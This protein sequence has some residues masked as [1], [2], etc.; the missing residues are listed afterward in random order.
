[1]EALSAYFTKHG[2]LLSKDDAHDLMCHMFLG[3]QT[4]MIGKTEVT[5]MRTTTKPRLSVGD[6]S[7]FMSEIDAWA[8]DKGCLLP[9]PADCEY[10]RLQKRQ[11]A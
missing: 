6:F 8:A 1:M 5:K 4:K 9:A 11:K 3:Y 2:R 10:E 7:H